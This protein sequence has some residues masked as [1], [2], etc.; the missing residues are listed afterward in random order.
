MITKDKISKDF[1]IRLRYEL[2]ILKALD[3]PNI[4]RLLEV[5]EDKKS[6]YLVTELFEA[7][8][9]YDENVIVGKVRE[10]DAADIIRQ[11]LSAVA[12]CHR[13]NVCH[14]DIKAENILISH[15]D[16]LKIRNKVK[17]LDFGYA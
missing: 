13:K 6:I 14:R 10:A 9:L 11:V 17:I 12:Y 3:H 2:D 16:I 4:V 5:Y 1:E 7:Q 8:E 15:P